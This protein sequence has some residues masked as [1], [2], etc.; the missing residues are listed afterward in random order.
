MSPIYI[1]GGRN[2]KDPGGNSWGLQFPN[3]NLEKNILGRGSLSANEILDKT[4]M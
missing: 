4:S 3:V 1:V 2:L